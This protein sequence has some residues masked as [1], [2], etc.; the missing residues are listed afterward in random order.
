MKAT[1]NYANRIMFSD[2]RPYEVVRV[3]SEN[4]IEV[5]EMNAVETEA[6]R[7]ARSNTFHE[8]G[9]LG[10]CDDSNQEW[11]ITSNPNNTIT[12]IR[13]HKDG[14]WYCSG[15]SKYILSDTPKKFYDFNF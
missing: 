13:R 15:G 3:L 6:S 5:R 11:D 14:K 8:G 7:K 10:N 2:I 9:F 1:K 12:T 4:R